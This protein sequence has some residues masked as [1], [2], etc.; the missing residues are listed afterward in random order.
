MT[1]INL[2][3]G[4]VE[5]IR[6]REMPILAVQYHPEASPGPLDSYPLFETFRELI[7]DFEARR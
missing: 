6:H 1:Q 5:G 3:D 7:R 2:N 4:T